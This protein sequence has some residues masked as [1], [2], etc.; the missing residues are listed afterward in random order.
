MVIASPAVNKT[1]AYRWGSLTLWAAAAGIVIALGFE[2]IGGWAPCPLCLQQRYAYYAGIPLL[3]LALVLLSA[4]KNRDAGLLFLLVSFAFLANASLGVY[5][6]GAEWQYWAGPDTCAAT[7]APLSK[8]VG[9]LATI[10][11]APVVRCDQAMGRFLGLSFAGW[12]VVLSVA[13]CFSAL[14]AAFG[15]HKA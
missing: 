2:L 7:N 13:L 12:N 11:K 9:V 1:A 6:A 14:K 4:G 10:S 5:H 8:T 15:N 3:F